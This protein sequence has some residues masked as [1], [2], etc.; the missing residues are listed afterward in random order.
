MRTGKALARVQI[1]TTESSSAGRIKALKWSEI[2]S[3]SFS[4]TPVAAGF[5][6]AKAVKLAE[7]IRV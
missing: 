6:E 2:V 1:P 7:T 5:G 4:R 3:A